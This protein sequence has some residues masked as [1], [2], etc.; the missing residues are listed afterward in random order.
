MRS[1]PTAGGRCSGVALGLAINVK[2]LPALFVLPM[3]ACCRDRRELLRFIA[4]LAL[5]ALPF[6]P[7]LV[8]CG[9]D[10]RAS[11]ATTPNPTTGAYLDSS[12]R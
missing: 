3:L 8:M 7:P 10:F 4:G 11:P 2:P 1:A 9:G 6:V 5:L 12:A